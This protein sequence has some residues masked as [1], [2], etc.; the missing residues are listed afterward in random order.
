[1]E[2]TDT[3]IVVTFRGESVIIVVTDFALQSIIPCFI[4]EVNLKIE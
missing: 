1:M 3:I 4:V 2:L